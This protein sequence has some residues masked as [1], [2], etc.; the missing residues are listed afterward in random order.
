MGCEKRT[1][2]RSPPDSVTRAT[3]RM[4]LTSAAGGSVGLGENQE[5]TLH[6]VNLVRVLGM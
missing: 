3:G 1:D 5:F 6:T 4:E 2:S